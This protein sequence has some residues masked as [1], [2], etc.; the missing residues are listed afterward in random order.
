MGAYRDAFYNSIYEIEQKDKE[1]EELK[2]IISK[3]KED[4][5]YKKIRAVKSCNNL[6]DLLQIRESV[7]RQIKEDKKKKTKTA[8]KRIA[9]NKEWLLVYD[10]IINFKSY[11]DE[12]ER[13]DSLL[14]HHRKRI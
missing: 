13:I 10:I 12:A 2:N 8:I 11:F 7:R 14:K 1:I 6:R 3:T 4:S 9:N 5:L